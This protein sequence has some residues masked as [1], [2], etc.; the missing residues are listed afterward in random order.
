MLMWISRYRYHYMVEG[1]ACLHAYFGYIRCHF[2]LLDELQIPPTTVEAYTMYHFWVLGNGCSKCR[3]IF[4]F[5]CIFRVRRFLCL[6]SWYFV[7][8]NLLAILCDILRDCIFYFLA[9]FDVRVMQINFSLKFYC[10]LIHF[11]FILF[12]V[13]IMLDFFCFYQCFFNFS[14]FQSFF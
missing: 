7:I 6:M 4:P 14:Y 13:N 2:L 12:K 1:E 5:Q 11:Y 3:T 8:L 10:S 9:L